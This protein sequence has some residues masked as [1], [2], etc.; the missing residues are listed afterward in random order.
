M[1]QTRSLELAEI[2]DSTRPLAERAQEMLE[3]LRRLVPFDA[4]WLALADPMSSSFTSV[5]STDLDDATL[6]YLSGPEITHDI[7]VTH[8]DRARLPLSPSDL[9]YPA[10]DL[11]TWAECFIPAGFHEALGAALF[12]EFRSWWAHEAGGERGPAVR[13]PVGV[14]RSAIV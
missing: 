11:P 12:P 3:G 1:E 6:Q 10:K 13:G 7:E 4:A 2:A 14:A 8:T 5:A 9:P